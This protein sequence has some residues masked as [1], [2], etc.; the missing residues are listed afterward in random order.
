MKA[1]QSLPAGAQPQVTIWIEQQ[2][3]DEVDGNGIGVAGYM[4]V[5]FEL[6]CR[7]Q[8]VIVA[9][10][11]AIG[12]G[13]P[14]QSLFIFH[15]ICNDIARNGGRVTRLVAVDVEIISVVTVQPVVGA[16]PNK[17]AMVL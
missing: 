16:Q 1:D 6:L 15:H 17:T 3:I 2:R 7:R 14:Q 10:E 8:A 13:Y 4:F 5:L 11:T 12:R 9:G